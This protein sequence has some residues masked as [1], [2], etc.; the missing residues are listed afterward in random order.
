MPTSPPKTVVLSN[1]MALVAAGALGLLAG[2]LLVPQAAGMVELLSDVITSQTRFYALAAASVILAAVLIPVSTVI[3]LLATERKHQKDIH[4][5]RQ[6]S[7][8]AAVCDGSPLALATPD[9]RSREL[10]RRGGRSAVT[11]L[12]DAVSDHRPATPDAKSA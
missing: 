2:R 10:D 4:V 1:G 11:P 12:V 7:A 3:T 5:P 9:R 8:L 6:E